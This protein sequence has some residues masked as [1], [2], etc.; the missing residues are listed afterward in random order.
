MVHGEVEVKTTFQT[1]VLAALCVTGG[2]ATA[3]AQTAPAPAPPAPDS[4]TPAPGTPAPAGTAKPKEKEKPKE[5]EQSAASSTQLGSGSNPFRLSRFTWNTNASTKIFGVGKDYI[6]TE[7]E[8]ASMDFSFTPRYSFVNTKTDWAWVGLNVNWAVELTNSDATTKQR[9]TLFGDLGVQSAYNHTF[10]KTKNGTFLQGGP[11]ASIAFP[12]SMAS[13][14]AGIYTRTA[15]GLGGASNITFHDG[16]WINSVFVSFGGSWQHT[17]S[18]STV[19]YNEGVLDRPRQGLSSKGV[20]LLEQNQNHV[21]AGNFLTHDQVSL[22]ATYYL[23]VVGDLSIGN[24]YGIQMPFRYKPTDGQCVEISNGCAPITSGVQN[25]N[26]QQNIPVTIF[27]LSLNYTIGGIIW[28]TLGYNN[29]SRQ[30]GEGG[31]RRSMFYSPDAQFYLSATFML[32]SIYGKLTASKKKSA[33]AS[34]PF[35]SFGL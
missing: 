28:A 19:P 10:V 23:A 29:S 7:D 27:D 4:V 21:L 1:M 8:V 26:T 30:L 5:E 35:A 11:R 24:S 17:F 20:G 9:Q 16:D 34:R 33:T 12:T 22:T 31:G 15:L 3:N 32:D 2:A 25:Q 14:A 18:N 6:G 13:Q